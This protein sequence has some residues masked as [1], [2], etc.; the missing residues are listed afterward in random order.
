M[1]FCDV[2]ITLME[3]LSGRMLFSS[4]SFVRFFHCCDTVSDMGAILV[5]SLRDMKEAYCYRFYI[6]AE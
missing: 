4:G 2:F 1:K 5:V 6:V 3:L